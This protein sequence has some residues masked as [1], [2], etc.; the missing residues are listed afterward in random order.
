MDH[1][2]TDDTIIMDF[3]NLSKELGIMDKNGKYFYNKD[4]HDFEGIQIL[5]E[6][7]KGLK[8][9]IKL[10]EKIQKKDKCYNKIEAYLKKSKI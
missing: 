6:D 8:A 5:K 1:F 10:Y 4:E 9:R 7:E 3:I 2:K